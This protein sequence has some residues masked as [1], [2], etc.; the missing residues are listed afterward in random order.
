[1]Y[2]LGMSNWRKPSS[3]L[4]C[5]EKNKMWGMFSDNKCL[6]FDEVCEDAFLKSTKELAPARWLLRENG[7]TDHVTMLT[8][9]L[10]LPK[11]IGAAHW[12]NVN[13]LSCP[14]S[15]ADST[16]C[17]LTAKADSIQHECIDKSYRYIYTS[18]SHHCIQRHA[19]FSNDLLHAPVHHL[20]R[21]ATRHVVQLPSRG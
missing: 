6:V 18:I 9:C 14:P 17:S 7:R 12:H 21:D 11:P 16:A 10:R 5:F 1:M 4:Q 3:H 13:K 2:F 15:S 20:R 19:A 8:A